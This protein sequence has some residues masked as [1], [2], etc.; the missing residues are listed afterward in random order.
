MI[1]KLVIAGLLAASF[2]SIATSADAVVYVR[3]AP[4]APREE[5]IP[6]ARRGHVWSAGHW[7]WRNRKHEWVAGNWVRERR[8]Y[9]Y[10]QPTWV[11][12]NGR[13]SMQRGSWRRGDRDGDGVPNRLDR[14]PDNPN[15]R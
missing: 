11:E 4:P 6:E 9:T 8:G 5:V 1:R 2:G 13:W 15:R 14:A 10:N 7:E 12:S 3:T